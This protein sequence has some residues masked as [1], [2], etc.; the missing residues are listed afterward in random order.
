MTP[1]AL[2]V[3][4]VSKNNKEESYEAKGYENNTDI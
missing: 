2:P 4:V 3:V 1:E